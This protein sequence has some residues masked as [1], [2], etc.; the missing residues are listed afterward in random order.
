M[1]R[2][3]CCKKMSEF[4]KN[5]RS[6]NMSAIYECDT[7]VQISSKGI[8]F[9]KY[10]GWNEGNPQWKLNFPFRFCPFCGKSIPKEMF[11]LQY[12]TEEGEEKC[13]KNLPSN[14][15]QKKK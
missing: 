4:D 3:Y 8:S 1:K 5:I 12:K 14:I 9:E 10:R 11:Y 2:K 15:K 6:W 7:C 13:Q